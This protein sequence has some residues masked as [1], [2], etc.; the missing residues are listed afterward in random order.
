[1]GSAFYKALCE[2][3]TQG[4]LLH[5]LFPSLSISPQ[6]IFFLSLFLLWTA[7]LHLIYTNTIFSL[8]LWTRCSLWMKHFLFPPALYSFGQILFMFALNAPPL[9][10][11]ICNQFPP[12]WCVFLPWFPLT[13]WFLK[14][15]IP[16]GVALHSELPQSLMGSD[17][18][19]AASPV[20]GT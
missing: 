19:I 5:L 1:M 3:L 6:K 15:F 4:K 11:A 14:P 18:F 20:L 10:E 7:T 8:A 12:R 13:S 2:S 17:M 9:G 16:F